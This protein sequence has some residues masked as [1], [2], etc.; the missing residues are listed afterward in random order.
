MNYSMIVSLG[1]ICTVVMGDNTSTTTTTM[2]TLTPVDL[3]STTDT[4]TTEGSTEICENG[5]I[6]CASS[7]KVCYDIPFELNGKIG[8]QEI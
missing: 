1:I 2:T 3:S 8:M 7:E 4:N 5:G 6:C